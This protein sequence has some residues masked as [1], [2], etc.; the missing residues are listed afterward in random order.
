VAFLEAIIAGASV[1]V[2]YEAATT[3]TR[4]FDP[5]ALLTLLLSAQAITCMET[6]R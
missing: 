1:P 6:P 5:T 3:E 4:D 2:A